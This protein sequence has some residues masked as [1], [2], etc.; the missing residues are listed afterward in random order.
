MAKKLVD[1]QRRKILG[2]TGGGALASLFSSLVSGLPGRAEAMEQKSIRWGFVG[3]GSIANWMAGAIKGADNAELAAVSSRRMASA[4][5]FANKHK[6]GRAFDSWAD[7][8]AWDGVDAIYVATPTSVREEIC[9]AA[10][11][12]GKHVIGE[13]PFANLPSLQRITTACRENGVGFMDG[14]HFV[15]LPRTHDI[16]AR[17]QENVGWPWSLDSAFQFNLQDRSNIRFNPKLEPMGAVGDAGW[18]NMRAIVEYLSPDTELRSASTYVRQDEATGAV[19]SGS[20]VMLF[21]DGST[22]TWNCGFDSGGVIMDLRISGADGV[23]RLDDFLTNDADGTASYTLHKGG[24][25]AD[26]GFETITSAVS[27]AGPSLMFE[28]FAAMLADPEAIEKSM[29][30]SER[31]QLLLDAAWKAGLEVPNSQEVS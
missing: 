24:F 2:A 29:E 22:S 25:G 23:V 6:I 30:V 7:M 5:T 17:M 31:T 8:T 18:Y 19:I 9:I 16:R 27:K 20:G 26:P 21:D 15:H 1:L 12:N 3:T 13:K 4:E 14:T 11:R 10:A 28:D